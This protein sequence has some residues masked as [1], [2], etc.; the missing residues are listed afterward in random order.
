MRPRYALLAALVCLAAHGCKAAPTKTT[1]FLGGPEGM[2]SV[3][4]VKTFHILWAKPKVNWDKFKKIHIAPVNMDYVRNMK[5]YEDLSMS[6]RDPEGIRDLA[7]YTRR[8][9]IEAHRKNRHKNALSV[10]DRPDAETFVL[11]LAITEVVPTNA[12]LNALGY[13]GIMMAVDKGSVAMEGRGRDGGTGEVV[14]KMADREK[15][16]Q[17]L[18]SVKDLTWHAHARAIIEEW[19]EQS[20]AIVNAEE[21]AVVQ[22]SSWWDW[23]PW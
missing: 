22:D 6:S 8:T 19:A 15:G 11:E 23:R 2:V 9:F 1:A 4:T 18:V 13:V 3:P 7:E 21:Y 5:W 14:L 16:K 10:V 17:S 20:V 12:W